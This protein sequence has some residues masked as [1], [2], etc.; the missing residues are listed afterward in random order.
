MWDENSTCY[1]VAYIPDDK[2]F[3]EV[4]QYYVLLINNFSVMIK[5]G[6]R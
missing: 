5:L 6:K 2:P 4:G 1:A 3:G